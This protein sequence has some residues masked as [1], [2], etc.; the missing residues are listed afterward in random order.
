[1]RS[2]ISQTGNNNL[3][4]GVSGVRDANYA[5]QFGTN[6]T[7]SVIQVSG[8]AAGALGNTAHVSQIGAGNSSAINQSL[9]P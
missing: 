5:N 7:L 2:D 4:D 3:V 1:M 8:T 9:N 6:N